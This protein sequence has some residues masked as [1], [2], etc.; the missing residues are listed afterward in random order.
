MAQIHRN[1][2]VLQHLSF[3][4]LITHTYLHTGVHTRMHTHTLP[5]K[6]GCLV[7]RSKCFK[8]MILCLLLLEKSPIVTASEEHSIHTF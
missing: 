2:A 3:S 1:V 6:A 5:P 7:F 8:G 4:P